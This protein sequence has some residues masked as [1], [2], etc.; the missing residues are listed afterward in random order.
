MRSNRRM[1]I[2]LATALAIASLGPALSAEPAR[3]KKLP[4]KPPKAD[5]SGLKKEISEH[6]AEIDRRKAEKLA[7]KRERRLAAALA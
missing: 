4:P 5:L 3:A 1:G 7:A 6:N 2:S